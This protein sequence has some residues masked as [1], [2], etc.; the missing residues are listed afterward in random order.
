M[1]ATTFH[2]ALEDEAIARLRALVTEDRI[3]LQSP[4]AATNVTIDELFRSLEPRLRRALAAELDDMLYGP[5]Y[6]STAP[7]IAGVL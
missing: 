4:E 3:W 2:Y 7:S 6:D 5:E 1:S